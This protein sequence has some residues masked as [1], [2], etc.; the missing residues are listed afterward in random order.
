FS[1]LIDLLALKDALRGDF[2][3]FHRIAVHPAS[4]VRG[5]VHRLGKDAAGVAV[6]ILR[7]EQIDVEGE[8]HIGAEFVTDSLQRFLI[9]FDRVMTVARVFERGEPVAMNPGPAHAA[10]GL[11]DH[12]TY[13][14]HRGRDR[15][16]RTEQ[17]HAFMECREARLVDAP[18]PRFRSPDA[19]GPLNV[20]EIAA[21]LGVDLTGDQVAAF[22]RP[23]RR[24]SKR[25]W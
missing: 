25:M 7:I 3:K 23:Y 5:D 9:G 6:V 2:L 11:M 20:G 1:L 22:D 12:V 19:E 21:T 4:P 18:L 16:A 15:A 13:V 24:H 14:I 8:H 10:T 17:L